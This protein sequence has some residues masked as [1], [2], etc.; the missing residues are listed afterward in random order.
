MLK[1]GHRAYLERRAQE[2][3]AAVTADSN[4]SDG[5]V[6]VGALPGPPQP[7][8]TPG[9]G[10]QPP[11]AKASTTATL[12]T[13]ATTTKTAT[14]AGN[15]QPAAGAKSTA[16]QPVVTVS[17][18]ATTPF[19]TPSAVV[20]P[21]IA[22]PSVAGGGLLNGPI[23]A[24]TTPID[25]PSF[26]YPTQTGAAGAASTGG[27]SSSSTGLSTTTYIGMAAGGIVG[28][29][30]LAAAVMFVVR[31]LNK[32]RNED[33]GADM[34]DRNSFIRNSVALPDDTDP[35]GGR[36]NPR[37]P[38]M[39][40]RHFKAPAQAAPPVPSVPQGYGYG[41]GNYGHQ[42]YYGQQQQYAQYNS[43][44]SYPQ[45]QQ[46]FNP[47]QMFSPSQS[48]V[49]EP[50]GDANSAA[51][52]NHQV[53]GRSLTNNSGYASPVS[54]L[55]RGASVT[56]MQAAQYAEIGRRLNDGPDVNTSPHQAY[57]RLDRQGSPPNGDHRG[58]IR[59][60]PPA[61]TSPRGMY[62]GQDAYAG[63]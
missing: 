29:A 23:D 21:S 36:G 9:G 63:I 18:T 49:Y 1:R 17:T 27:S 48:P 19:V 25:P 22:V 7:G 50:Y 35:L 42:D 4:P 60:P 32:K 3:A 39:I 61:T 57:A 44:P 41:N 26:Y 28:I 14:P 31:R 54:D 6:N 37:P 34:F 52:L 40:E 33:A 24:T 62:H 16:S 47:G 8:N 15:T 38:T 11:P 55:G 51:Y 53:G 30:L 12:K 13:P 45:Y 2:P 46:S 56:P 5:A 43:Q 58:P 20:A 59:S 10:N